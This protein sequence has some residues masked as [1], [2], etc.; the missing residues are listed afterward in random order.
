LTKIAGLVAGELECLLYR[1]EAPQG[2]QIQLRTHFRDGE[3]LRL[4]TVVRFVRVRPARR[5]GREDRQPRLSQ[6]VAATKTKEKE[7][8]GVGVFAC[9]P[10]Q[11]RK[12]TKGKRKPKKFFGPKQKVARVGPPTG[13]RVRSRHTHPG[14]WGKKNLGG[15]HSIVLYKGQG[16]RGARVVKGTL[17]GGVRYHIIGEPWMRLGRAGGASGARRQVRKGGKRAHGR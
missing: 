2:A 15:G 14:C 1:V 5:L 13:L 16:S 6:G 7:A 11:A 4:H 17:A 8:K 9:S 12:K 10:Y 3:V